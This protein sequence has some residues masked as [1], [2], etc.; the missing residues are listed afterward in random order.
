MINSN[1]IGAE[2][3]TRSGWEMD[4]LSR[5]HFFAKQKAGLL[6]TLLSKMN[7]EL[8]STKVGH[9]LLEGAIFLLSK[10]VFSERP[11][12]LAKPVLLVTPSTRA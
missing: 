2:N 7:A 4:L 11:F 8:L 1:N 3:P 9:F 5:G 12:C 10:T 6:S